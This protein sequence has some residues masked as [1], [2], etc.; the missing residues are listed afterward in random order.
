MFPGSDGSFTVLKNHGPM[1]AKL[2]EGEIICTEVQANTQQKIHVKGGL[3]RVL[4]N[5]IMVLV[6]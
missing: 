6:D 5:E 2:K 4:K 1:I 3:V